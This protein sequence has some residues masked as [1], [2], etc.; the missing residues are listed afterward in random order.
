MFHGIDIPDLIEPVHAIKG[1]MGKVVFYSFVMEPEKL[2]K[3]AYIAHRGKT[4]GASIETYQRM[5]RKSRLKKI[6]EYIHEK[7]GIFPTSIVINI[8][9]NRPLRFDNAAEMAG[10]NA[11][12]GTLYM[13]T[14]F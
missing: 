4:S 9:T 12:L 8:E 3:I 6:A 13:P 11:V 7:E 10:N 1:K 5:A 2:L 14:K